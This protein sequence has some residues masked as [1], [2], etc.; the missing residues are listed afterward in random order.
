M[1]RF[2]S[3]RRVLLGLAATLGGVVAL[4]AG[5]RVVCDRRVAVSARDLA[6]R[7]AAALPDVF[8]PERLALHWTPPAGVEGLVAEVM[9]RP[10]L[11]AALQTECEASRRAQIRAQLAEDFF[12]GDVVVVDRL[13]VA[14]S[15]CVIAAMCLHQSRGA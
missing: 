9:A 13:V 3:R 1:S 6:H 11:V 15:E 5:S 14:R 7:L 8:A 12:R 4:G 10:Q 2:F